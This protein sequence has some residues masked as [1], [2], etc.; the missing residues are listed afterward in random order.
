MVQEAAA[1]EGVNLALVARAAEKV[2][3]NQMRDEMTG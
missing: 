1:I 3:A 2:R